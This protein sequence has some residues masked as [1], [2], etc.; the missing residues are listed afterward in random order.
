M[1]AKPAAAPPVTVVAPAKL[2]QQGL[3]VPSTA[4]RQDARLMHLLRDA[5]H[6]MQDEQGWALVG[7][8]GTQ[9]ANKASFDARNY[10]YATLSKLLT[11]TQA[12]EMRDEG[13]SRV[14]VRDKR[15]SPQHAGNGN[16]NGGKHRPVGN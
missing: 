11:A 5:V 1:P 15:Q 2:P 13:T 16:G 10:G 6:A 12:F 3:R 7:A 8:V 14:A 4:L 9:I